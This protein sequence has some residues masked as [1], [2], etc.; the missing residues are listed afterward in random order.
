MIDVGFHLDY[1]G[2]NLMENVEYVPCDIE[3]KLSFKKAGSN[4]EYII[5]KNQIDFVVPH[6]EHQPCSAPMTNA[7]KFIEMF[8]L[9][10]NMSKC[11]DVCEM[12]NC[13]GYSCHDC[14]IYGHHEWKDMWE[15]PKKKV[16]ND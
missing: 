15:K 2:H 1:C 10:P 9:A 12:V 11:E 8:G 13:C 14:P 3:N 6:S 7:E 5:D 4:I 16:Q